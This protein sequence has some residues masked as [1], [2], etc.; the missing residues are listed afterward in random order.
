MEIDPVSGNEVPPG[1]LPEEVRDDVDSKLSEGEYVIPA[2][3][4]RYIGLEKLESM[5]SKAEEKLGAMAEKGRIGG[6][7]K[8]ND[9][10]PA[11]EPIEMNEGGMVPAS[12]DA[13]QFYSG[14]STF[15]PNPFDKMQEGGVQNRIYIGPDGSRRVVMFVGDD[16]LTNIPAGFV[17][18]TPENRSSLNRAT[19]G[20]GEDEPLKEGGRTG[21]ENAA[22]RNDVD[23]SELSDEQAAATSKAGRQFAGLL[24]GM[25]AGPVGA[26]AASELAR[27]S[28][29]ASMK[30]QTDKTDQQI[31]SILGRQS[32]FGQAVSSV[33]RTSQGKEVTFDR[34]N[35]SYSYDGVS[36]DKDTL[37]AVNEA[38]NSS[39]PSPSSSSEADDGDDGVGFGSGGSSPGYGAGVDGGYFRKGGLVTKKTPSKKNSVKS[40]GLATR[41]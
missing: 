40:K 39:S 1:A 29:I 36:I 20:G 3:V 14:F 27:S 7:P 13:N 8:P 15:N 16:P 34:D 5:V 33:G 28:Q 30:D 26:K 32:K 38:V 6:D 35:N 41:Y 4:A 10:M 23:Y 24:G 37:D 12:V 9:E 19:E 25:V 11:E 21:A 18:D 22:D 31:E 2:N 17:E